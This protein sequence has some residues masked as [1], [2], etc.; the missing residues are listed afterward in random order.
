[1]TWFEESQ[2]NR[3]LYV[4]DYAK[5]YADTVFVNLQ[6][7]MGD[8]FYEDKTAWVDSSPSNG[9]LSYEPYA[10]KWSYASQSA[11]GDMHF[12]D[13]NMDCEN[14]SRFPDSR[15]VSEFGFQSQPS[16]LTYQK[17]MGGQADYFKDSDF[18]LF[19]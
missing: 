5:L 14:T 13:Y 18:M 17:V 10:K 15:F 16:F 19:R 2:D 3:D 11:A 8:R 4:A 1:M 12:Y 6:K 9:L 7:V